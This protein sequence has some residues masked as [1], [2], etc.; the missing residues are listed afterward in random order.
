MTFIGSNHTCLASR[1]SWHLVITIPNH[2]QWDQEGAKKRAKC[3]LFA[4]AD[5]AQWR[6]AARHLGSAKQDSAGW[7]TDGQPKQLSST[8][9]GT[10]I[11][12]AA[13]ESL[14]RHDRLPD[15]PPSQHI[16]A[17]SKLMMRV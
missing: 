6:R 5:D 10:S 1:L 9:S 17:I 2:F 8:R 7:P 13:R 14:L 4:T 12:W 15:G 3:R 11:R 16:P